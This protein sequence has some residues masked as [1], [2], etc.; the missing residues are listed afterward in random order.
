[1]RPTCPRVRCCAPEGSPLG[2]SESLVNE[3]AACPPANGGAAVDDLP[4]P[5]EDKRRDLREEAL[6]QVLNG[7][8]TPVDRGVSTVM[9]VGETAE[10]DLATGRPGRHK[11]QYV[12]LAR[13]TTDRIFVILAEFGNERHPSYPDQDTAPAIPGP[14]RF[15]GPLHNEIPEP[16]RTIDNSTVW[17][18]DY[19]R[20][21]YQRLYFGTDSGDESLKQYYEKQSSGRVTASTVA[22]PTG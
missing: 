15:D 14:V 8:A 9:K 17:Q 12:E 11:D 7:E 13:E 4:S 1:L 21:N 10:S 5:L 20:E 22:S 16:D 2:A 19:N 3:E 6:T 18:A